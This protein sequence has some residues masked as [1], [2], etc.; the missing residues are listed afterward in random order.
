MKVHSYAYSILVM[1]ALSLTFVSCDDD[2]NTVEDPTIVEFA[3]E[4]ANF[5][6]LV[7]AVVAADLVDVLNDRSANFTL[8]A[9]TNAAFDASLAELKAAAK[10][11]KGGMSLHDLFRWLEADQGEAGLRAFYDEVIGDSPDLRARLSRLR[12]ER[13]AF[14]TLLE[15]ARRTDNKTHIRLV[16]RLSLDI[17]HEVN[18]LA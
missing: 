4:N 18:W 17:R 5:S 12:A 2:D 9:P 8:F 14:P 13:A 11:E 10:P 16:L 3:Q 7:D 1:L 15:T 6:T